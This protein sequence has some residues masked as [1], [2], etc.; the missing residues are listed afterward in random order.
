[1]NIWMNKYDV[2]G[3]K[4]QQFVWSYPECSGGAR[5][6]FADLN[7]SLQILRH[8]LLLWSGN[9]C[10]AGVLNHTAVLR[11]EGTSVP[12]LVRVFLTGSGTGCVTVPKVLTCRAASPAYQH[13]CH[14]HQLHV[15][16]AN[17][18]LS[19]ERTYSTKNQLLERHT[20][21]KSGLYF[22]TAWNNSIIHLS[23][24]CGVCYFLTG[25]LRDTTL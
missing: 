1:M 4:Y 11:R 23:W 5:L 20:S 17:T 25:L 10:S 15:P 14:C 6:L 19:V 12:A 21:N 3:F 24:V 13:Q 18:Q 16:A 2:M 7:S 22:S 8:L 9:S